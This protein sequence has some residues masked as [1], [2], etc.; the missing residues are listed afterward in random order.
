MAQY[1]VK[2]PDVGEGIAEAEIVEWHVAVGDT[3]HEDDVLAEV[4]T[5]KATVELPS[6]VSGVVVW[7]GASAG[8]VLAVG[9]DLLRLDTG[10]VLARTADAPDTA[11]SA[12]APPTAVVARAVAPGVTSAV[13]DAN[14]LVGRAGGVQAAPAVRERARRLGVD[15]GTLAGSGPAGRV[16]HADL[17]AALMHSRAPVRPV[18]SVATAQTTLPAADDRE[19]V[20]ESVKIIGLRRNIAEFRTSPTWTRST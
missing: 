1:V 11:S 16:V 3:I 6:P 14:P 18:Q 20:V 8:D 10:P 17:D 12:A 15:L 19:D 13:A 2:L 7:L 9:S 4:M 5:D